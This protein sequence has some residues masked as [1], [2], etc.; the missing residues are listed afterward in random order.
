M[1]PK[2]PRIYDVRLPLSRA[3]SQRAARSRR[4]LLLSVVGGEARG[5]TS[6]EDGGGEGER[7]SLGPRGWLGLRR[8]GARAFA[9]SAQG[10]QRPVRMLSV[11]W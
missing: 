8:P 6:G 1:D 9:S 2:R 5:A 10:P 7:L 4:T 11:S 3:N